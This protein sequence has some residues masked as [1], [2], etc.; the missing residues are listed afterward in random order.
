MGD[1]AGRRRDR[2]RARGRVPRLRSRGAG[3]RDS[4]L[5]LLRTDPAD[6]RRLRP[7]LDRHRP[8]AARRRIGR[9]AAPV[10][11]RRSHWTQRT[12]AADRD[13]VA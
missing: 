8:E 10:R 5:R 9:P 4:G 3:E 6:R 11:R 13:A 2:G 7:L 1:G 12:D